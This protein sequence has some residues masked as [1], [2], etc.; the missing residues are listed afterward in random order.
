MFISISMCG[1][2]YIY[3]YICVDIICGYVGRS[4]P[5]ACPVRCMSICIPI[6]I[7]AMALQAAAHSVFTADD[8]YADNGFLLY[9]YFFLSAVLAAARSMRPKNGPQRR[10]AGPN[11]NGLEEKQLWNRSQFSSSNTVR[12][13]LRDC[14]GEEPSRTQSSAHPTRADLGPVL[15]Q[16]CGSTGRIEL[17]ATQGRQLF[18]TTYLIYTF[19]RV[20]HSAF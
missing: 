4:Y 9:G 8:P 12:M 5:Y 11:F 18:P 7:S 20:Q 17:F 6:S 19:S 14:Y 2:N 15:G 1:Y 3:I 16:R 13:K 10:G